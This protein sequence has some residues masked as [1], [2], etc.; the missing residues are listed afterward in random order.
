MP[1]P[2]S[3]TLPFPSKEGCLPPERPKA[4]C[5]FLGDFWVHP[6]DHLQPA[7]PSKHQVFIIF[8]Q[9]PKW[10]SLCH[11]FKSVQSFS[12]VQL[13][14]TPWT[15]HHQLPE[16]TQTHVHQV[17]DAIQTSHPL[18]P[19]SPSA[20]NFFQHQELFQSV[21]SSHQV[22]KVLVFQLQHQSFQ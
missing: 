10:E 12:H 5:H 21:S 15:V 2:L 20:F 17:G 6:L 9:Q 22:A 16:F 18:L 4:P 14:V 1:F 19:P 13:F 8:G 7:S 11:L 3:K